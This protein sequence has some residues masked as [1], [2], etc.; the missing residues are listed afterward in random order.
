[1]GIWYATRE[2]VKSA[3]DFKETARSNGQVDRL[4][5]ASSGSI[6]TLTHR[7]FFPWTGTRYFDW[8]SSQ[9]GRS[10]RLWLDANE[11]V[12]IASIVSG[13]RTIALLDVLLEPS[14]Y[15]P[16]FTHLEVNLG[17]VSAFFDV[18]ST[19]QRNIAITGLFAGCPDDSA[20]AGALAEALDASET[21]VDVTDSA[22]IGVGQ[23][24]RIGDERMTV[25]GKMMLSTAQALQGALSATNADVTVPVVSGTSFVVG[26]VILLDAERMLIVDI[27][28]NNL[29]VKRAWDGSVLATHTASTI[30][31]ARTLTVERGVLGTTA[32]THDTATAITKFV[33]P[34]LVRQLA[35]A[36]T[37]TSLQQESAA[38]GR[39]V[40]SGDNARES[41]GKGIE[42]LR[43]QVYDRHGRKVRMRV[44]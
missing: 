8:P 2:D 42:D 28:G 14:A 17:A 11:L 30:Y 32:A 21:S 43:N 23:L 7:K 29:I 39:V 41:S 38:Y 44:V 9:S 35:I 15:G 3:L 1:M 20:P 31:A 34:P 10:Y 24:I 37:I 18:G 13:G 26:E 19:H 4:I 5:E 16:P 33:V 6:E 27:A 12:S 40:G 25:T 36:E 22:S